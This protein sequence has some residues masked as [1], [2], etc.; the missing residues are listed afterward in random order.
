MKGAVLVLLLCCATAVAAQS[1]PSS[2]PASP[3]QPAQPEQTSPPAEGFVIEH[4]P[5]K[6]SPEAQHA[7]DRCVRTT[8]SHAATDRDARQTKGTQGTHGE[9][10]GQGFRGDGGA[11]I[12]SGLQSPSTT[13]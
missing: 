5:P 1:S 2:Q 3:A 10:A 6:R 12:L 7:E 9:C 4:V 8:T 13:R 11:D